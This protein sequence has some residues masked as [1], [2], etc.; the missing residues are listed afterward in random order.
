MYSFF[1][2]CLCIVILLCSN[3]EKHI[4]CILKRSCPVSFV[5]SVNNHAD[6]I[7]YQFFWEGRG[8]WGGG[9]QSLLRQDCVQSEFYF[10]LSVTML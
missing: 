8:V 1:F 9:V 7:V 2:V 6:G 4:F 3:K 10:F 5:N